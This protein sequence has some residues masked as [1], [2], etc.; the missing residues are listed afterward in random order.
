M[1][2]RVAGRYLVWLTPVLVYLYV[3]LSARTGLTTEKGVAALLGLS[4]VVLGSRRPDRCL[5]MLA[6]L[7][8][9]QVYAL[10][11]L[12]GL[13][14][15]AGIIRPLGAW[16]EA[17]ALAVVV[18]GLRAHRASGR[19]AGKVDHLAIWFLAG[20]SAYALLPRLF[21]TGAP[22]DLSVRSL[23]YR[24]IAGFVV[25]LLA[26]RQLTFP[27]GFQRRLRMTVLVSGSIVAS[28]AIA[29]FFF[30]RWWNTFS[31]DTIKL[32]RYQID[33]LNQTP[34]DPT[35]LRFYTTIAGN[36]VVRVGSVFANPLTLGFYLVIGLAL[37]LEQVIRSRA[38]AVASVL[39]GVFALALIFTQ[40]RSAILAGLVAAVLAF[41]PAPGRGQAARIRYLMIVVAGVSLALPVAGA[42]GLTERTTG[43][44]TGSDPSAQA[45]R[46]SFGDGIGAILDNPLG[47]G[48]GTSAGQG[49]R[50]GTAEVITENYYLQVGVELGV[51]MMIVFVILTITV[52]RRL[53]AAVRSHPS[54]DAGATRGAFAGIAVGALFLHTWN[55]I[56][57]AWTL[58]AL[59][60][61]ILATSGAGLDGRSHRSHGGRTM[62]YPPFDSERILRT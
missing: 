1:D 50:F 46:G 60:G 2:S 40:T 57:T 10:S 32:V 12:Y 8:P 31:I 36:K 33:V 37:A 14:V 21:F 11:F 54:I 42:T 55:D 52:L 62:F 20:L 53:N 45:H 59:A 30:D 26:A 29:E 4:V 56:A 34:R 49:Q 58:W 27:E 41:R 61:V 24:G 43:A 9:F 3:D 28:V 18:A 23:T 6:A 48:L 38:G 7:L 25:L 35:D 51:P 44:V 15:P 16:K 13:G 39:V 47:T 19:K 17:L 22:L 5:L